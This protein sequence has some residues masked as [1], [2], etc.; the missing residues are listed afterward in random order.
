MPILEVEIVAKPDESIGLNLASLL[1][2]RAGEVFASP[3]GNTWV[4]V[5]VIAAEHY[6]ENSSGPPEGIYPVFV[7]ILKAKLPSPDAM[8]MEV[9]LLTPIIAQA[10]NRPEENVHLIYLPEGTGRVAFGG[11]IVGF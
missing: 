7:S 2:H 8:Q 1:A 3:A 10:C 6:A 11:R 5:R 4:K 9:A